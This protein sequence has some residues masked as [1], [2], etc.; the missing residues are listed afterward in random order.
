M[1]SDNILEGR[2]F[3]KIFSTKPSYYSPWPILQVYNMKFAK[4]TRTDPTTSK[5]CFFLLEKKLE[6]DLVPDEQS[7]NALIPEANI[8][9]F[10]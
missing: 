8:H 2:E 6:T 5:R 4:Y 10:K 3:H 9:L 1:K 7:N